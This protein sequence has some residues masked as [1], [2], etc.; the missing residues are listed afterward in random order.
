MSHL[1][2][3]PAAAILFNVL[4]SL[5]N[6][7]APSSTGFKAEVKTSQDGLQQKNF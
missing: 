7:E 4:L 2:S 3:C 5:K 6:R 1:F